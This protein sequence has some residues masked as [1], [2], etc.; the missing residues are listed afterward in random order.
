MQKHGIIQNEA[1]VNFKMYYY[2][3][4]I[5]KM[6]P[7]TN[8]IKSPLKLESLREKNALES[9]S[10]KQRLEKRVFSFH[11]HRHQL[12]LYLINIQLRVQFSHYLYRL[13]CK[14]L[15]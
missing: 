5:N 9:I 15:I 10:T 8:K 1:V 12:C 2:G 4:T 11:S 6:K 3:T 13:I 14:Q 7:P